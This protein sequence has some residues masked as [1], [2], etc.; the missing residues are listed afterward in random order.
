MKCNETSETYEIKPTD[1]DSGVRT[2]LQFNFAC[3]KGNSLPKTSRVRKWVQTIICKYIL[4]YCK[5]S[6]LGWCDK[7]FFIEK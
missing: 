1:S 3:V 6:R 4:A 5:Y 7:I 2:D